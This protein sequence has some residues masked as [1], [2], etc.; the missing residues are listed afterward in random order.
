[1][2]RHPVTLWF[3]ATPQ[4]A[5]N[6]VFRMPVAEFGEVGRASDSIELL[7][8]DDIRQV[9]SLGFCQARAVKREMTAERYVISL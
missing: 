9:L 1:M 2:P 3:T 5:S 8:L 6:I 4:G 7:V